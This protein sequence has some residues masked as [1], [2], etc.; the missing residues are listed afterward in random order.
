MK[1]GLNMWPKWGERIIQNFGE[2]I[3]YTSQ[4]QWL[5]SLRREVCGHLLPGIVSSNTAG[6]MDICLLWMLCSQL[7]ISASGWWFFQRT[8]TNCGV[9]IEC[10]REAPSRENMARNQVQAPWRARVSGGG[11]GAL[12]QKP[13]EVK[14]KERGTHS[15][16]VCALK[17]LGWIGS[18]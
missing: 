18:G 16:G 15:Y 2:L 13:R 4:S 7:Q 17:L 10:D 12:V 3:S 6:G 8:S 11:E 1:D 9:S 5:R 14:K